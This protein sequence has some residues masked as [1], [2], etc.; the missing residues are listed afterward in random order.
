TS[1]TTSPAGSWSSIADRAFRGRATTPRG[2]S[3]RRSGSSRRRRSSR[4]GGGRPRASSHGCAW[5][6]VRGRGK[7]KAATTHTEGLL[8]ADQQVEQRQGAAQITIPPGP[9]L[10]DLVIEAKGVRKGYGDVL[11]MDD[12][13]FTLPKGGIVG[14]IG[15]NGAGKT[16][17]F[18]MITGQEKPD[19]GQL[20][21]GD[22]VVMAYADR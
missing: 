22:T 3:R 20:R 2:S 6:R 7:P 21:I 9:R 18:R 4:H 16:T 1:S 5:R 15:P 19:A 17:L 14:V 12:V 13:A 11:L 8:R 10:G